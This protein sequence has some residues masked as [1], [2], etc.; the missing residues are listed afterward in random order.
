M[1][2]M[3]IAVADDE[4]DMRRYFQKVLSRMGHEVTCVAETGR[5]LVEQCHATHPDLVITDIKMPDMDGIEAAHQICQER[6]IPIILVS[7][8]HDRELIER[9]E[10]EH[11]LA[12]S[13]SRSSK[14]TS[15]RPSRSPC[16][17][18]RNSKRVAKKRLTCGKPSKIAR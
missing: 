2:T 14:P 12:Y 1:S 17:S 15:S 5:Q 6:L 4:P 16:K 8:Y 10:A 13:L 7:G 9:A 3:R 18:S 11:V